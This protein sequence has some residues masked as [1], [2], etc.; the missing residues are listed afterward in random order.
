[1]TSV[2]NFPNTL[3]ASHTG[4]GW[5]YAGWERSDATSK[6]SSQVLKKAEFAARYVDQKMLN[7][8]WICGVKK[9]DWMTLKQLIDFKQLMF[10]CLRTSLEEGLS[11]G[12]SVRRLVQKRVDVEFLCWYH[13]SWQAITFIPAAPSMLAV[14]QISN[15]AVIGDRYFQCLSTHYK[16]VIWSVVVFLAKKG[17]YEFRF[18]IEALIYPISFEFHSKS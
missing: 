7:Y 10:R 8:E 16:I 9:V 4:P 11:V 13:S 1:M 3:I 14:P 6:R 18:E 12:P 17:Q 15:E 5:S 2:V